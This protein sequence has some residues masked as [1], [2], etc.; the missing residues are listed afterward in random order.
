MNRKVT[1]FA[2]MLFI[3]SGIASLVWFLLR[4][5]P[6][7][8]RAFYPCQRASFP[9]ATSFVIWLIGSIASVRII[10]KAGAKLRV[11]WAR[12]A[13]IL[14]VGCLLF[15]V[16][17]LV[18]P[19][20]S[21]FAENLKSV[22][23]LPLLKSK[24]SFTINNFDASVAVVRSEKENVTA[25]TAGDIQ[26]LVEE[27]V[28]LAGGLTDII[29]DGDTVVLKPN[30][31]CDFNYAD[32]QQVTPGANG[33]VTDYRVI[34][35]VVNIVNGINPNGTIILLEG[36]ALGTTTEN[37]QT[38][39]WNLI[40]G[41]DARIGI[42]ES[43]GGWYEYN[44]PLLVGVN[45]HDSIALYPDNLKPNNSRTIY[46]N[47]IY[48]NAD[49]LISIPVL[50]NHLYTGITGSVKN[51]GIGA[52]P[53]KIYGT[54]PGEEDPTQRNGINH[55]NRTNLHQW[56]HDFYA[57]RPVDFVI[58][59]GLQGFDN[60]PVGD[61]YSSLAQAQRNMRL[62]LA[63]RDPIALDAVES[64]IMGHDPQKIPHLVYLHNDG[65]G[66]A[67]A[68]C[69]EVIG[70][71]V[72][73]IRVNFKI[74]D[75]G[76]SS[77]FSNFTSRDYCINEVS[78]LNGEL[79][80]SMLD[81][82]LLGRIEVK[83]DGQPYEPMFIGHFS[84]MAIPLDDITVS[85][86]LVEVKFVDKYLNTLQKSYYGNYVGIDSPFANSLHISVFP[87]PAKSFITL[88]IPETVGDNFMVRIFT[89]DGKLLLQKK[90]DR[91]ARV[92]FDVSALREGNYKI[93]LN[94]RNISA[95]TSFT[96]IE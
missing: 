51:V 85:D 76:L 16:S 14:V 36:S 37:M 86:S 48:H 24:R 49:V 90:Y 95:Q 96:I 17:Y 79:I 44:S 77:K 26:A 59:D 23:D 72:E 62:I 4:V 61:G 84:R 38:V 12:G 33:M 29:H 57:C 1:F 15:L 67:N 82:A 35:A 7:P 60:G 27:A 55:N 78:F 69:V 87:N 58:M 25:I 13:I 6:K 9:I 65:Y 94:G 10:K 47:K 2:K 46:Q 45:L 68:A 31:V 50:K 20:I 71:Q 34:Q 11:S 28:E 30:L 56:I 43:S 54:G 80:L 52:T 73:N 63:G 41:L 5:I 18:A 66:C 40:S 92:Q 19:T 88:L 91:T 21:L 93:L 42:E 74:S 64:L 53:G 89:I 3:V 70:E 8:S 39:G 83:I 75:S 22:E 32:N 81:T